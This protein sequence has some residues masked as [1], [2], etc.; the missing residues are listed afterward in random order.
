MYGGPNLGG[1]FYSGMR[2]D[3]FPPGML[4]TGEGP[5]AQVGVQGCPMVKENAS[6]SLV[7]KRHVCVCVQ[8][9]SCSK[10]RCPSDDCSANQSSLRAARAGTSA[11][12]LP[13]LTGGS[14]DL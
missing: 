4:D 10:V 7:D 13:S 6:A 5:P 12:P 8:G 1:T 2:S 14:D 9:T 3:S 11:R